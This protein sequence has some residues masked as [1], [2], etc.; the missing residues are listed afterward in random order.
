LRSHADVRILVCGDLATG[1][2]PGLMS[3]ESQ[4]SGWKDY[5]GPQAMICHIRQDQVA[6]VRTRARACNG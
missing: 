1:F 5:L 4:R 3:F 2:D 6:A